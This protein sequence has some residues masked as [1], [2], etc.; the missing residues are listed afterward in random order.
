MY[1]VIDIEKWSR[2]KQYLWFS[3]FSN[4][5]Y[6]FNIDVDVTNIVNYS[7]ETKTSFFINFL[8]IVMNAL[9]NVEELRLRIVNNEVRLY[10][11]INPTYTVLTKTN[12]FENCRSNMVY[13]YQEFYKIN[14]KVIEI[15]K[16]EECVNEGYNN[17]DYNVYYI[18]CIPWLEYNSMVH[19][20]PNNNVESSSVPRICWSKYKLV[21]DRYILSFNLTVSHV[22]V[23]G[24][25]CSKA[26]NNVKEYSLN[27]LKYFIN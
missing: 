11:D 26:L 17:E 27:C 22:L 21:N 8:F 2:K 7:K 14:K 13:N 19:P 9:N 6:G 10:D 1:K 16:N 24:F 3:T 25:P 15:A 5:D 23:D 18:T 4:P 20:L 12:N